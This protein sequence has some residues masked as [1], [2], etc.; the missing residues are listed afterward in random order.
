M[1]LFDAHEFYVTERGVGSHSESLLFI[2][3]NCA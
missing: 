2:N 3:V 1:D